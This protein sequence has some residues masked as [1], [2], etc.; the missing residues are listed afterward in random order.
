MFPKTAK[1]KVDYQYESTYNSGYTVYEQI[2]KTN[3]GW[4]FKSM[5][6]KYIYHVITVEH[7]ILKMSLRTT[8]QL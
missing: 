3:L 7:T 1:I 4:I 6:F 8:N 5:A 2:F